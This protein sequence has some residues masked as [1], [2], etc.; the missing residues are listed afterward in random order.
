MTLL[1]R[2]ALLQLSVVNAALVS[3]PKSASA[4]SLL[5][6][7]WRQRARLVTERN[8][9]EAD[10]LFAALDEQVD[11]VEVQI[12]QLPPDPDVIAARLLM[13]YENY[14]LESA[15]ESGSVRTD[16]RWIK[17][18]YLAVHKPNLSGFIFG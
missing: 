10:T 17:H 12:L 7:L 8:T 11:L 9:V 4:T 6:R 15:T 18:A 14:S 3:S 5:E 13:A 16:M 1:T 2:R